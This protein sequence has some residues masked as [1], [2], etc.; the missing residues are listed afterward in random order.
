MLRDFDA[1][2]AGLKRDGF[3]EVS[4]THVAYRIA[5]LFALYLFGLYLFSRGSFIA[6]VLVHGLFGGRCGWVQHE[7]NHGSMTESLWFGKLL[8]APFMGFGIGISGDLWRMMHNKHHAATQKVEHDLDLDTTPLVA[9]FDTAF[10]KNRRVGMMRYWT[11]LQA[12][13]FIPVTSGVFVMLFWLLCLH[14]RRVLSRGKWNEGFA[15]NL[16]G[17]QTKKENIM[18]NKLV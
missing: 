16:N 15:T 6:G 12:L 13:L 5:E 17:V 7:L 4:Y 8:Q 10:E 2:D 11:R 14:P 18:T 9:F 3:F 1:L